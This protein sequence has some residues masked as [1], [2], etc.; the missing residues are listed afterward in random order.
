M[1]T[2][3]AGGIGMTFANNIFTNNVV[4]YPSTPEKK[5]EPIFFLFLDS[6]A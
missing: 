6:V 3:F 1:Q 2:A 5:I 4:R